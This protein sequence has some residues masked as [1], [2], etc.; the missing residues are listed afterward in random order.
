MSL[1]LRFCP[2]SDEDAPV[3]FS[4]AKELVDIYENVADIDYD[5][6]MGWMRRKIFENITSYTCVY[7][8][9]K[10]A[11]YYCLNTEPGQTELDDLYVLPQFRR[12]GI[13]TAIV[14]HCIEQANGALYLYVFKGNSGAVNLYS[15]MGFSVSQNVSETRF[16]MRREVDRQQR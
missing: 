11:G 7:A 2:A 16:I 14:K 3:I 15:R 12:Q 1:D 6:V 10:K 13:G 9:E 8:D 4:M 5:K